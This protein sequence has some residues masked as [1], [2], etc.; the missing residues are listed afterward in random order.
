[1]IVM[2]R[3]KVSAPVSAPANNQF[4]LPIPIYRTF[5]PY[6]KRSRDPL[7]L[8][9]AV[10]LYGR[11]VRR[12]YGEQRRGSDVV[13]VEHEPGVTTAV[14]RWMLDRGICA[15]MTLGE[16]QVSLQALTDVDRV[17]K[18]HGLSSRLTLHIKTCRKKNAP[19]CRFGPLKHLPIKNGPSR[20]C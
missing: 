1:M 6:R 16:P 14:E 15:P 5:C 11:F 4:F 2:A 10:W 9:S 12:Y 17:L 18:D 7:P 8:A 20:H 19:G 3:A 13:V